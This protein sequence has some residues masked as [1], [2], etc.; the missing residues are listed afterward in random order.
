M[1]E[2]LQPRDDKNRRPGKFQVKELARKRGWGLDELAR[3]SG[4]KY[5][6]VQGVWQNRVKDPRLTTLEALAKALGVSIE[7]LVRPADEQDLPLEMPEGS[8]RTPDPTTT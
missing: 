3:K 6:T 7:N 2:E 1:S 4:L 5:A 8:I